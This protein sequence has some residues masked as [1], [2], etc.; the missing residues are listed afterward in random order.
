MKPPLRAE[1]YTGAALES[2]LE[3]AT[4]NT[5]SASKYVEVKK[6]KLY[7]TQILDWYGKDFTNPEFKGHEESVAMYVAKYA[8][9]EVVALVKEKGK[10][11]PVAFKD[12]NWN[13]NKQ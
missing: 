11:T 2:Q 4:K 6:G 10:K 1:A 13:L 8:G 9:E 7:L 3:A 5:L 12:Y